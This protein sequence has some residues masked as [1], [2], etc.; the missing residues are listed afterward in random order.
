MNEVN[1]EKYRE[2]QDGNSPKWVKDFVHDMRSLILQLVKEVSK[3]EPTEAYLTEILGKK[4]VFFD[5]E[6]VI[7]VY[8]PDGNSFP[9]IEFHVRFSQNKVHVQA[10]NGVC[11]IQA[12]A[13]NWVMISQEQP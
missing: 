6:E 13:A 10:V 9:Q 11:S 1:E 3:E 2:I 7:V 12:Q 8:R 4:N 5:P